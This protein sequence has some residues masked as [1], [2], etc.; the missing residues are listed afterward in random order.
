MGA[1]IS[2]SSKKYGCSTLDWWCASTERLT[3][4]KFEQEASLQALVTASV[5]GHV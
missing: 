4:G 5:T 2:K 3:V 1:A